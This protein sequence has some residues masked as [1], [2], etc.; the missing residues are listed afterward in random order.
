MIKPDANRHCTDEVATPFASIETTNLSLSLSHTFSSP[1]PSLFPRSITAACISSG[2]EGRRCQSEYERSVSA[3]DGW[4]KK[5]EYSRACPVIL[6]SRTT[7]NRCNPWQAIAT[8]K[9]AYICRCMINK[10]K[11]EREREERFAFFIYSLSLRL[12]S[13]HF[14]YSCAIVPRVSE[15]FVPIESCGSANVIHHSFFLRERLRKIWK[16]MSLFVK[17]NNGWMMESFGEVNG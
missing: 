1:F 12:T 6:S 3:W 5:L 8:R 2:G 16:L 7:M 14:A 11:R 10:E 13:V 15:I 9:Q 4:R 17:K